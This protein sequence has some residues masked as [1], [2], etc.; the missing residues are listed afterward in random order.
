MGGGETGHGL[1]GEGGFVVPLGAGGDDLLQEGVQ[2]GLWGV[3]GPCSPS[4]EQ[5]GP[6]RLTYMTGRIR[7]IGG[8]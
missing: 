6:R 3:W 4:G 8:I 1:R 7:R 5:W 2:K